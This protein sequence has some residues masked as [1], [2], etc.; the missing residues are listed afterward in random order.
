MP[1]ELRIGSYYVG[2]GSYVSLQKDKGKEVR[3]DKSLKKDTFWNLKAL[4]CF[5]M[6]AELANI[7]ARI[8]LHELLRLFK[9]MREALRDVLAN[10]KTFLT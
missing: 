6:L 2:P 10:S 5:D 7:L 9:E 4:F 8:T 1:F 3:F